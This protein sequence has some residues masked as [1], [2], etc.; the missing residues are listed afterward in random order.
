MPLITTGQVNLSQVY[1]AVFYPKVRLKL[2]P[3]VFQAK[4]LVELNTCAECLLC[5]LRALQ[6]EG[7]INRL[8][9]LVFSSH[10][11]KGKNMFSACT[12]DDL[13][14]KQQHYLSCKRAYIRSVMI[15]FVLVYRT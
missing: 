15:K 12:W 5:R 8:D 6:R 14:K 7:K 2:I 13:C 3:I 1:L 4:D 11:V 10:E 9:V